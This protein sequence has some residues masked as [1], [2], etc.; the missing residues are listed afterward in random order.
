MYLVV[1]VENS[2]GCFEHENWT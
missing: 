2:N 1:R